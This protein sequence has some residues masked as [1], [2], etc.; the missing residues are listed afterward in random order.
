ML[1]MLADSRNSLVPNRQNLLAD[2]LWIKL[3]DLTISE[4]IEKRVSA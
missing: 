1:V 2:I 3:A 4:G